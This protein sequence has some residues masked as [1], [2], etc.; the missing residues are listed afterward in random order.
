[1]T[2]IFRFT[3]TDQDPYN[4]VSFYSVRTLLDPDRSVDFGFRILVGSFSV[5]DIQSML[6]YFN[7]IIPCVS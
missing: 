7:L 5:H 4:A 2:L 1:M 3:D 6:L